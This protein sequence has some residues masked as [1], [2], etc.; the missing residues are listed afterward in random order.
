[1]GMQKQ[2]L[3]FLFSILIFNTLFGQNPTQL[4]TNEAINH[5]KQFKKGAVL[6]IKLPTS[7]KILEAMRQDSISNHKNIKY[8]ERLTKRKETIILQNQTYQEDLLF[9]LSKFYNYSPFIGVYDTSYNK[10]LDNPAIKGV[11][12]DKN[13]KL[14]KE[15]SLVGKNFYTFRLDQVFHNDN[16]NRANSAFVLTNDKG[17][18]LKH[19][20][21][22]AIPKKFKKVPILPNNLPKYFLFN[23]DGK[24]VAIE[25]KEDNLSAQPIKKGRVISAKNLD[26]NY[27]YAIA[28][29]L[30][31]RLEAFEKYIG[32]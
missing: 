10:L 18:I 25:T 12:Y 14:V 5:I 23:T 8:I 27:Y 28:K 9:G 29:F 11:F 32:N 17:D 19:P 16:K 30:Q 24:A 4:A 3:V 7:T 22:F 21:P 2:F 20:F 26:K 1:M 13:L 6:V 15:Y 31:L